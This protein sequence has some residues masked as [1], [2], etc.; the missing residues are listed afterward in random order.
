V[1]RIYRGK[2]SRQ[3]PWTQHDGH[4]QPLD[5]QPYPVVIL[6]DADPAFD[7]AGMDVLVVANPDR[8]DHADLLEWANSYP[9]WSLNGDRIT[10]LADA[11]R[12]A[13]AQ[14]DEAHARA[15]RLQ[16]SERQARSVIAL[17]QQ[18]GCGVQLLREGRALVSPPTAPD[19]TEN[20]DA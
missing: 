16:A 13:L 11:L 5:N 10:G 12:V 4:W 7:H 14:R 2:V 9:A 18:N 17:H 20:P 6:A 15:E 19:P 8:G 3:V 1:T